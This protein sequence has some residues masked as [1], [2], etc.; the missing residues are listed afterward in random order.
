[1]IKS[2][3]I[4]T[5]HGKPWSGIKVFLSALWQTFSMQPDYTV[6]IQWTSQLQTSHIVNLWF[7]KFQILQGRTQQLSNTNSLLSVSA[8]DKPKSFIPLTE[9]KAEGGQEKVL[10]GLCCLP[11]ATMLINLSWSR[12]E[13]ECTKLGNVHLWR[14]RVSRST[15]LSL[16]SNLVHVPINFLDRIIKRLHLRHYQDWI[17]S[18]DIIRIG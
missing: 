11:L 13:C 3:Q 5:L 2:W 1:M 10:Q 18:T 17:M 7:R 15:T 16:N 12:N 8:R 4:I 9:H 14:R 6:R